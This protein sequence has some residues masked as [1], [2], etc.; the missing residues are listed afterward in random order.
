MKNKDLHYQLQIIRDRVFHYRI[1][2]FLLAMVL[3]YVYVAWRADVLGHA[4]PSQ[5][6]ISSKETKLPEPHISQ[7]T[8]NKIQQLQNNNVNVQALFNQA[9][10]DPF[11]E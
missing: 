1:E 10:Q 11:Q 9:R 3:V 4:Q 8:V 7:V 6:V 2:L 5:F